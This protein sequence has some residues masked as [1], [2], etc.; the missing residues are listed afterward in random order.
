MQSDYYS[1]G[2]RIY[3]PLGETGGTMTMALARK[4]HVAGVRG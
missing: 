4:K 2:L 3:M 1:Y